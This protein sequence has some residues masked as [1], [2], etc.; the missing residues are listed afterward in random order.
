MFF[1]GMLSVGDVMCCKRSGCQEVK[2]EVVKLKRSE[3]YPTEKEGD[4]KG[5][6]AGGKDC[7]RYSLTR[8]RYIPIIQLN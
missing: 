3:H 4:R 6:E 8:K 7:S 1:R 5:R 2:S